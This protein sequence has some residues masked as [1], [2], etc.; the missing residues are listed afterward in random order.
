MR[1]VLHL[2]A[3]GD[4]FTPEL[5]EAFLAEYTR[6]G[7]VV[8]DPFAGFGTT[9]IVAERMGRRP[10]GLEIL[11]DRVEFVRSR[12]NDP[13]AIQCAD[14]R[15]LDR[16]DL[17]RID[18][19]ITSPPYMTR[20]DHPQNPLSGYQTLDG[21][22]EAYLADLAEI[23]RH[24]RGQLAPDAK[25]VINAANL[26]LH[27]TRLAWDIGQAVSK[28]LTYERDIVIDWDEPKEWFTNDYC[29]VFTP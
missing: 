13:A 1:G 22:Y 27:K 21:D 20:D 5:V 10:L 25:V 19:S 23:Y 26:H 3:G 15:T 8:F 7:D 6:P 28:V 9:L 16:L 14:A 17:P 12:L 29:L 4:T 18:F 11:P 2:R 24:L